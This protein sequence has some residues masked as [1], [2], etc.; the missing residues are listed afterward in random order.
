LYLYNEQRH[1]N[2][3]IVLTNTAIFNYNILLTIN[4][5]IFDFN[6]VLATSSVI[7]DYNIV[8]RIKSLNF[9]ILYNQSIVS[10]TAPSLIAILF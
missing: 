2:Y 5:V 6:I 9:T 4:I 3:N 8:L 10:S 7:F 1:F